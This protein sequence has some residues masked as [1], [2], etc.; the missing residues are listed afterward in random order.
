MTCSHL[1]N[2]CGNGNH[3]W[4]SLLATSLDVKWSLSHCNCWTDITIAI[5][6]SPHAEGNVWENRADGRSIMIFSPAW[7]KDQYS[8]HETD[9]HQTE[10]S[11]LQWG[12]IHKIIQ[13]PAFLKFTSSKAS[14]TFRV[15][16]NPESRL[17][18]IKSTVAPISALCSWMPATQ[19][20]FC[21]NYLSFKLMQL[22][23]LMLMKSPSSSGTTCD[24]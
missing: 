6:N 1:L 20:Y 15:C 23:L 22:L 21:A 17:A 19:P 9:I 24:S 18:S 2:K 5:I 3:F 14:E 8:Q 4:N 10:S 11:M 7:Y 12:W 16:W 13:R